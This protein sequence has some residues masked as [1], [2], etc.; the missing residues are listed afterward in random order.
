MALYRNGQP[1]PGSYVVAG[2]PWDLAGPGPH[3]ASATNPR[4]IKIGGSFPQNT[5]ERNPCNCRMDSLM[6]LNR[7]IS[8]RE[9]M[10]QFRFVTNQRH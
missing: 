7:A 10:Q 9:V 8:A 6:F 2:D 4:G 5:L 3:R 1:V